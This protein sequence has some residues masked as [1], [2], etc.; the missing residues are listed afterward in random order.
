GLAECIAVFRHGQLVEVGK[1]PQ[2][3]D[4]PAQAYTRALLDAHIGLDAEPLLD[5]SGLRR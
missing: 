2:M 5:R 4:A 3:I 1:T